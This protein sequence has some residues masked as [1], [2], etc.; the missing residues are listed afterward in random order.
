[1]VQTKS[2]NTQKSDIMPQEYGRFECRVCG[3][4]VFV[5]LSVQSPADAEHNGIPVELTCSH[6]HTD[7][8][9]PALVERITAKAPEALKIRRAVAGLG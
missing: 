6:G 5:P 3:V 9:D 7:S 2:E 4:Q 1:M 8:Y